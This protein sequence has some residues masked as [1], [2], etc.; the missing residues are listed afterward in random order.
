MTIGQHRAPGLP[1][2]HYDNCT[3]C[4]VVGADPRPN[5]PATVLSESLFV[6]LDS[7][8]RGERAWPGAPP[9]IPHATLM[10]GE[11]TS[12]HGVGGRLGMRS[13]H[14][15]RQNCQQCHAPSAAL[16]QR[17]ATPGVSPSIAWR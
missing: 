5:G 14:P 8:V 17:R 13:P 4:H 15:D 10:R 12:C 2:A 7:P 9:T 11:C 16:N 3:Q 6:G 1:H